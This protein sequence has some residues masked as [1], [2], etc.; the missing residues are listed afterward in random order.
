MR[1]PQ[2]RQ[3]AKGS[4][5]P[6]RHSGIQHRQKRSSVRTTC[7][8]PARVQTGHVVARPDG[9]TARVDAVV[10]HTRHSG[11]RS[12]WGGRGFN[13]THANF[14]LNLELSNSASMDSDLGVPLDFGLGVR[15]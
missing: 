1:D 9:S 3:T 12:M 4:W 15:Q 13:R 7:T 14:G 2:L 10:P 8:A 5:E 6:T 11:M